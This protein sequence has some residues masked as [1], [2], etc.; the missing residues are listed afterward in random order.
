MNKVDYDAERFNVNAYG[1]LYPKLT[2]EEMNDNDLVQEI[3]ERNQ[4]YEADETYG[5]DVKENV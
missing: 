5:H 3:A 2:K 1:N 4:G